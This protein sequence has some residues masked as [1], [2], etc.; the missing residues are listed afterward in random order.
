MVVV[1]GSITHLAS[2]E[3]INATSGAVMRSDDWK[4]CKEDLAGLHS[5]RP[6]SRTGSASS[7]LSKDE[8]GGCSVT[9]IGYY[10]EPG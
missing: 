3:T 5:P 9:S 6:P 2:C 8:H 10:L 4:D 7:S 1:T